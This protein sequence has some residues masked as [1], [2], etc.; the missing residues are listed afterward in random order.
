MNRFDKELLDYLHEIFRNDVDRNIVTI[1][2]NAD[3]SDRIVVAQETD[4]GEFA[5]EQ[6][7]S[8]E[9]WMLAIE[10]TITELR[11]VR[12]VIESPDAEIMNRIDDYHLILIKMAELARDILNSPPFDKYTSQGVIRATF[13]EGNHV[14]F[15]PRDRLREM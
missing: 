8:C 4:S 2:S 6:T 7:D 12:I 9:R 5:I 3:E 10:K 11:H 1:K 15:I 14:E 13:D